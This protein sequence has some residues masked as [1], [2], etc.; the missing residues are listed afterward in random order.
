M[1]CHALPKWNFG[2]QEQ[3]DLAEEIEEASFKARDFLKQVSQKGPVLS[4]DM[5]K[6]F[7]VN[8]KPEPGVYQITIGESSSTPM[9]AS[10]L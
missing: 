2:Q 10:S 3:D 8:F 5:V 4:P 7:C 6:Q 9:K 1:V